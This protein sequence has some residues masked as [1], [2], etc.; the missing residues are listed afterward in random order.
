LKD[1]I[2]IP[3]IYPVGRLDMDS[4]GL[5][6]LTND[7]RLKHRLTEPK[8]NNEKTY[9]VQVEGIPA[10]ADL[11]KFRKGLSI[12]GRETKRA[13]AVRLDYEPELPPRFPPVR[14]RKSI[15]TSWLQV[16]LT[17]GR[18]RQVRKMTAA[19]GF[20]TL[21]LVRSKIKDIG[22]NGLEEGKYR[23]LKKEEIIMLNKI[24]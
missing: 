20:P 4:E 16:T 11:E 8:F 2:D 12:E 17:E 7:N 15:P 21:R 5:L 3:G 6:I 9:L 24:N 23:Y 10:A 1:F 18:N 13:K 19:I 14:F 22:I